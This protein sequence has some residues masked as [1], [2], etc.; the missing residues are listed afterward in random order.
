[1]RR[2]T[3][4]LALALL[5]LAATPARGAGDIVFRNVDVFDGAR[6]V[7]ATTVVVRD[8]AIEAV[9]AEGKPPPGGEVIDGTG[10]MLLPGLIDC[11][12]HTFVP[13]MLKQALVFGVTTELD[14]FTDHHFAASMRK[15]QA[16]GRASD[17]ADLL[18]AGTLVTAPGGH[19]TQF[20]VKIP[21]IAA[22]EEAQK[23]VDARVEEGSD[24]IKVVYED[25]KPYGLKL[26]TVS[27][28]TLAAV[29]AAAHKRHKRAVVHVSARERARDAVAA[30]ADGL[31]HV[32]V[33]QATDDALVDLMARKKA[34]VIPTLTVLYGFGGTPGGKALADDP[35]LM[36]F[37]SP[38][39]ARNLNA[40]FPLLLK[41]AADYGVA[42][43]AVRKLR[44]AGVPIL[45][46]TDAPNPGTAHGASIH[47]ELELLVGAGLTPA[48]ALAAA[49][50]VPAEKFNLPDRGRIA[51][52]RRA[53]L[54]LVKGDPTR[55]VKATRRIVGVW[56]GGRRVG[57]AAYRKEV[58]RQQERAAKLRN[59]PAPEGLG[60]GLVSDFEGAEGDPPKAA[61]GKGWEKST[62]SV[63]GGTSKAEFKVVKGGA[64]GSKGSLLITGTVSDKGP[65]RWA[66]AIFYP[67][68]DVMAPANLL[69]KKAISFWAKGDG[70]TYSVML[71]AQS[72]GFRPSEKRFVAGAA[73]K[74]FRFPFKDFNGC[75]GADVMG[76]FFGGSADAGDF[77]LQLDDVRFE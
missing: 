8:G 56:K 71:F 10:Q 28:D 19:G 27:R 69:S 75:D 34:F 24:Y 48:E 59:Q 1:M 61:F 43:G 32:Y 58:G 44:A 46:G 36:P 23:F 38:A 35:D 68:K 47:R 70:R 57:R 63:L 20:G 73:W 30:G 76:V 52:K 40:S 29:I 49:T 15:Q 4:A 72:F 42:K 3:P 54:V 33:D 9:G 26:P 39:D 2:G 53:D 7:R 18:S 5:N 77:K 13:D 11:H 67:G 66:G 41:G 62:D 51:P 17:R 74:Q 6:V 14:M 65:V 12:T 60:N 31:V 45:A 37:I 21:T 22:P 50:S 25:G 55:D 64:N 16:S